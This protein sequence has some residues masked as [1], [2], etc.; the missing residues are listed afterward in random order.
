MHHLH[1]SFKIKPGRNPPPPH[2]KGKKFSRI[3]YIRDHSLKAKTTH[4]FGGKSTLTRQK[5]AKKAPFASVFQNFT[6]G[7]PDPPLLREDE[8][9]PSLAVYD[10]L[11]LRWKI[12][13]TTYMYI[14][15][16]SFEGKNYTQLFGK[17][18][19][20]TRPKMGSDSHFRPFFKFFSGETPT[21]PPPPPY[22]ERIKNS[23][24]GCIRS[25]TGKVKIL[26]H[27][28][29]RRSELWRQKLHKNFLEKNQ[30]E[31]G[32]QNGLRMHH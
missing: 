32:K 15:V 14:E 25:S 22:C 20:R 6:R 11:Q 10:P 23:P 21:P 7:D 16:R 27:Y 26:P 13:R 18:S 31:F 28:V 12:S 8:K 5:W 29:Y 2:S 3:A 1:P 17:K 30:H 4:N 19:T 24:F 9:L